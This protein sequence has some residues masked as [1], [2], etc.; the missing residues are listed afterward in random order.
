MNL[1]YF[2]PGADPGP[3]F[4]RLVRDS[5]LQ[6]PAPEGTLNGGDG[7]FGIPHGTTCLAVRYADGVIMAGDRRATSGHLIS[8]RNIEKVFP[9]D[10]FSGVAIAGAAAVSARANA[11]G[12]ARWPTPTRPARRAAASR[13]W[14]GCS[15]P[16]PCVEYRVAIQLGQARRVPDHKRA[17]HI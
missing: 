15:R 10:R 7:G 5:G 13:R 11:S 3:D 2:P 16:C 4:A 14:M 12:T 9:G 6:P 17:V 1:P 8:H